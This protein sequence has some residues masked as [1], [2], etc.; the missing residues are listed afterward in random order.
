VQ[1]LKKGGAAVEISDGI[2]E[3]IRIDGQGFE[4]RNM[5]GDQKECLIKVGV[6]FAPFEVDFQGGRF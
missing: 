6:V 3:G 4:S 5:R 2:W 1:P